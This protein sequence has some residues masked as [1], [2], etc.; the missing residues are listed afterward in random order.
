MNNTLKSYI[1][2]KRS[3]T[4]LGLIIVFTLFNS[5]LV[6]CQAGGDKTIKE[7]VAVITPEILTVIKDVKI[8]DSFWSPKLRLWSDVTVND[9]FNKFEGQYDVSA[10]N[11]HRG[12]VSEY[13]RMGRTRN[14][15]HNYDLV[16]Q[17]K[18]GT[19]QMDGVTF[20]DGLANMAISGA[21]SLL[22][23]F[24][25]KDIE[26]RIDAYSDRIG[27]AQNSIGDGFIS[28]STMLLDPDHRL[29][30]DGGNESR[31]RDISNQ[32]RLIDGAVNYY[33]ATGKTNLL[34]IAVKSANY[35]CREIGPAP[36]KNIIPQHAGAEEAMMR[37]YLLFKD[38]PDVK[39]KMS[40]T[41]NESDYY[42][43]AKF[44]VESRGDH[45]GFPLMGI[46]SRS[47]CT[48]WIADSKYLD[49]K[50]GNHSRPTWG[51]YAQDS[52]SV[53]E[54]KTIEG[55]AVRATLLGF[56]IATIAKES[57]EPGYIEAS[58]AWWDNMV[59]KKMS[60]TGGVGS[61][62][63]G[64]KF[65]PDYILPVNGYMETCAG[66]GS[67]FFSQSMAEMFGDGK[68]IDE[69]ERT[70]YNV[71]L[72]A[73]SLSGDH[74]YYQNPIVGEGIKRWDWHTCPCCPPMFLK[75]VGELP[76]FI[77][78]KG[79]NSVYVNL[80][81][82]SEAQIKLDDSQEV[83]VKQTTNYPW[84]GQTLINI[85]PSLEKEFTVKVRIPG[86][87][88][89]IENPYG[90]YTSE[91]KSK[92][93]VKLNGRKIALRIDKGYVVL[94]RKWAKGDVIELNL[95][96]E[97]RFVYA[98]EKVR[99]LTGMVAL[100]S[101]PIVYG[102]EEFDNPGLNLYKIDI[103]TPI[104][105]NYKNEVLN[106]VNTITGEALTDNGTKVEFTAVPYYALNNRNP[107]NAFK[108]WMPF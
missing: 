43:I 39:T 41:V 1:M 19:G 33:L 69:L 57:E 14:A 36:K 21:S 62:A 52:I 79:V 68:Y 78:S 17:G 23:Q 44:W 8:N 12:L 98:N 26:E 15:F 3:S 7:N 95:P 56:G 71:I 99:D 92:A 22:I 46:W 59:G 18:R 70:L 42:D 87:A 96:M 50:F 83:L 58:S 94:T 82:G 100:A 85:E 13:E 35:L 73:T 16:A 2:N 63:S 106:G 38:N 97:P 105:I 27:A 37:L 91:V 54:I 65:A 24:P 89:G 80:F 31:T 90:L 6:G 5:L 53:F 48:Q 30:Y 76:K 102:F 103:N 77:Y 81:V 93:S 55:H 84:E 4:N 11:G 47:E 66:V 29:G 32:G 88:Q 67:G 107:G 40:E 61:I 86:W 64:E 72:A 60:I 104:N 25:D 20:H 51:L 75:I 101:G 108:V 45:C 10:E 34:D 28:T 9:V 74:Y 49:P